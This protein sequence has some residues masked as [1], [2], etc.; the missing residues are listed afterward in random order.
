MSCWLSLTGDALSHDWK[1]DGV[2]LE[3]SDKRK[4]HP[5]V[6]SKLGSVTHLETL[7]NIWRILTII[8]GKTSK[9]ARE[10]W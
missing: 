1:K 5:R 2:S 4:T 3:I 7:K 6:R 9:R 10:I 8:Q